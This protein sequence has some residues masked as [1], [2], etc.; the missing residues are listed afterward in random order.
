MSTYLLRGF[1]L[2]VLDEN[3]IIVLPV[4]IPGSWAEMK[5]LMGARW[6][7]AHDFSKKLMGGLIWKKRWAH[8]GR[9][10]HDFSFILMGVSKQKNWGAPNGRFILLKNRV[11]KQ[12]PHVPPLN[13]KIYAKLTRATPI[14]RHQTPLHLPKHNLK[15]T[16]FHIS[17]HRGLQ[18]PN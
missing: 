13:T 3:P 11:V 9:P 7:H 12:N 2:K 18:V 8:N 16:G 15:H 5:K 10:A 4:G 14:I 1:F 17:T 6:A